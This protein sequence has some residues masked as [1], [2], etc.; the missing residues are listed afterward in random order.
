MSSLQTRGRK[1]QRVAA[2]QHVGDRV[3]G[4][5]AGACSG[6]PKPTARQLYSADSHVIAQR[7]DPAYGVA[8][9]ASAQVSEEWG[10]LCPTLSEGAAPFLGGRPS[11]G[12][13]SGV[14]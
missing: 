4:L 8:G 6:G 14:V 11:A 13:E 12:A 7:P 9:V 1:S 2:A 10:R 3:V 5:K